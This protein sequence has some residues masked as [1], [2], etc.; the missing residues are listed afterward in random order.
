MPQ[1]DGVLARLPLQIGTTATWSAGRS[2]AT[3]FPG[4]ALL[5]AA[6]AIVASTHSVRL[7]LVVTVPGAL[8]VVYALGHVAGA[9]RNRASDVMLL[10][11]GL[12][13]DGGRL[14]RSSIPWGELTAPFAEVEETSV[15]RLTLKTILL[16][17]LAVVAQRFYVTSAREPVRVWRLHVHHRGRRL[18]VGETERPIERD[19]MVAAA[20]SVCAVVSGQRYVAEAPVVAARIV[21]C[22]RCGGPAIPDD[23]PWVPC[24]YCGAEVPLPDDV[25][26]QA[27]ATKAQSP[28]QSR[29]GE[30]IARLRD[31]PRAARANVWLLLLSFLMFGA[32][33]LGWG[34][35]AYRVLDDGFQLTDVLCLALPFAAV[36]AGF[37]LARGRLA[38]RGALQL[39]TL[40][41][42]ALAP[43]RDG[44]PSRCRRCQAPLPAAGLGGVSRCRYCAAENI[45]GIDLRPSVDQARAEQS[46][47]DEALR[48]RR[49]EKRLWMTLS[50]VATVALLG[51]AG[52]TAAY[53]STMVELD[54]DE[55]TPAAAT[56]P[57]AAPPGPARPAPRPAPTPA[58]P[59]VHRP[60]PRRP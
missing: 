42:G 15:R 59:P 29:T 24:A 20:A 40:G 18:M 4:L 53:L 41:F 22:A 35:I 56:P 16:V 60:P 3:L 5:G 54:L 26:G 34:L 13:V 37:F 39:L 8:L 51:W 45:V 27:A 11:G 36:L 57:A 47:F 1:P 25:R 23:A 17:F 32:W 49:K 43:A 2:A 28:E 14:H 48:A 12:V 7:G 55:P 46:G 31:Q 38:D 52:G 58:P 33:P 30:V 10:A 9:V 50:L 6:A 19:S 21:S 44:A